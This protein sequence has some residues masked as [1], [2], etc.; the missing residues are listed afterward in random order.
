MKSENFNSFRYILTLSA[1]PKRMKP[2]AKAG[3]KALIIMRIYALL[4]RSFLTKKRER[5]GRQSSAATASL[6]IGFHILSW[7]RL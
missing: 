5:K 7:A 4:M 1:T 3:M 6:S 2:D